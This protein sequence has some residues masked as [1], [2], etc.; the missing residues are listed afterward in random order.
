M[1]RSG[2]RRPKVRSFTLSNGLRVLL[3]PQASS[4]TVSVWVWYRVG[5]KNE[6]PG[7]TGA[8][9]WVEHMLFEGSPR[10]G[11]GEIDRAIQKVGGELNAFTD[12]DFTAYFTTVPRDHLAVP[13]DIEA[14]RM[15]RAS[16]TDGEVAR[17]RT[18]IHSER[19]G[20]ENWPEFRVEEELLQL[21]FRV[22][23]Y[24]WD[25]LGRRRD[26]EQM[27][28]E[29]LRA[30][31]RRFYGPKNAVLVIAGGFD[32]A[33]TEAEVRRRF[34]KLPDWGEGVEVLDVEPPAAGERRSTLTGPG[35]TPYIQIGWRSPA[36][37][38]PAT[39]AT[40]ILDTILGGE[41]RLF[42]AGMGWRGR[43]EHPT[44]RLYR[45][46][47]D[48]G[49]A[50]RASSEW[51]PRAY[52]SLFSIQAQAAAGVSLDRLERGIQ[53]VVDRLAR[54]GPSARE[55]SDVAVRIERG[56]SL[57]YEGATRTGFRLGYFATLRS[58]SL[59][60]ELYRALLRVSSRAVRDQAR[61]IFR[62]EARAVVRYE[63]TGAAGDE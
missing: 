38:D 43:H 63:P 37:T 9:H 31:Y 10:Y 32:P 27:S 50:V 46:L 40:M 8:S 12:T 15:T 3:A 45:A 11:K 19:E 34:S 21:A 16:I 51:S 13:L 35:T 25:A 30:Y 52:P 18:V 53:S 61:A 29:Q 62:P 41:S 23:P 55:M 2:V 42:S 36:L 48:K 24:R 33:R 54:D 59:E 6:W 56:A 4:P 5:S 57:S 44:A 58:I 28:A 47:V 49:L 22:H 39:P 20:A 7:I 14:D 60:D 1:A 26:I 17:E